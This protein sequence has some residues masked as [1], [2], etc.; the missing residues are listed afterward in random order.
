MNVL[1]NVNVNVLVNGVNMMLDHENQM[2]I[3]A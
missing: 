3:K 2:L 1:V